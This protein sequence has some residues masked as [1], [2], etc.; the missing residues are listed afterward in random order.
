MP[1]ATNQMHRNEVNPILL[2]VAVLAAPAAW[3][4]HL[5][6]VYPLVHVACEVGSELSLH[7]VSAVALAIAAIGAALSWRIWQGTGADLIESLRGKAGRTSFMAFGGFA[8]A[9]FMAAGIIYAW[10]PIFVLDACS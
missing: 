9:L 7:V 3:A 4:A 8:F 10:A 6:I 5:M 2:W 1:A